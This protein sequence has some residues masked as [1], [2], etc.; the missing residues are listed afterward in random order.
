MVVGGEGAFFGGVGWH[1]WAAG[2]L[3]EVCEMEVVLCVACSWLFLV[4]RC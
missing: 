1:F 3:D 4:H 2:V